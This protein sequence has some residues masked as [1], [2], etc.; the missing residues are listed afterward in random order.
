MLSTTGSIGASRPG[1]AEDE[2][3]VCAGETQ[4][5]GLDAVPG[6]V[7]PQRSFEATAVEDDVRVWAGCG[8]GV[9][10][11]LVALVGGRVEGG[12]RVC[13]RWTAA[14]SIVVLVYG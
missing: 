13:R 6:L 12:E 2:R 4:R 3:I 1:P 11:E 7:N 5:T 14:V 9:R 8:S 10:E